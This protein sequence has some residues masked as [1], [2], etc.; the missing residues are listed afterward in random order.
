MATPLLRRIAGIRFV[1]TPALWLLICLCSVVVPATTW[2]Q[3]VSPA[4]R[5][6]LVRLRVERGGRA[7]DVE[8]LL[9]RVEEASTKGLPAEPLTNKIREG[10]AKGADPIRI[11]AVVQQMVV[12]LETSDRL[13]RELA[14]PGQGRGANLTLLAEALGGGVTPEEVR[15]I[16]RTAQTGGAPVT[17]VALV[18]PDRLVSAAK[19]LSFIKSARLSPDDGT[20][21]MVEATRRGF[22]PSELLELG[23]DVKRR[24][25][26]YQVG[27]ANLRA[28]RDAIAR[29]DRPEQLFPGSRAETAERPATR[30]EAPAVRPEPVERP[31]RPQVPERPQPT[32]RPQRPERPQVPERPTTGR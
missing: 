8:A 25:R 27:R 26:D 9:R 6:T 17:P 19:G 21:V 18:A 1:E 7:E 2:A 3:V 14:A 5:D 30:P 32:E 31:E 20:A 16:S 15:E 10:L 23:R 11:D 28:L 12:H 13:L 4:D 24:E 22:R 29:G